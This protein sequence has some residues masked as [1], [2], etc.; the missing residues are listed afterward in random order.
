MNSV[1]SLP[2]VLAANQAAMGKI[3]TLRWQKTRWCLVRVPNAAFAQQA[4]TDLETIE[5]M[6][7]DACLMD[8]ESAS[9]HW[10]KQA[11]KLEGDA[12]CP[13]RRAAKLTSNFLLPDASGWFL[14]AKSI[15]PMVRFIPHL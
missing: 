7:F 8:Y 14:T 13:N 3:S 2:D 6:F 1:L 12:A 11:A 15:C 4:D 10:H 9:Q 5:D